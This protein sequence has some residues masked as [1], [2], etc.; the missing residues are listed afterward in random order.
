MLLILIFDLIF[1]WKLQR[2]YMHFPGR[3]LVNGTIVDRQVE[4]SLHKVLALLLPRLRI[5]IWCRAH[6]GPRLEHEMFRELDMIFEINGASPG[7][8]RLLCLGSQDDRAENG[9]LGKAVPQRCEQITFE[10]VRR[11]LADI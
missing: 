10:L 5:L 8:L 1:R 4:G 7:E 6:R 9:V 3:Y 11:T 2:E